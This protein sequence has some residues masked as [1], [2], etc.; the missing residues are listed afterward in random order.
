[1]RP[2]LLLEDAAI[3]QFGAIDTANPNAVVVGL[4]PSCFNYEKLNE[5]FALVTSGA[6][7][8]AVNKSR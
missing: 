5:A 4:A 2:L 1:M 3:E 7:L 8:V 6:R